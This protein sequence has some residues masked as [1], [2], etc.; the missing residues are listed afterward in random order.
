MSIVSYRTPL[1]PSCDAELYTDR[2]LI[3]KIIRSA[4]ANII[5]SHNYYYRH[6][7]VN[8]VTGTE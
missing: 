4:N 8:D 6:V 7:K 1:Q 5:Q 2:K 3:A